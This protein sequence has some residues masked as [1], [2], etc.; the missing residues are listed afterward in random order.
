VV[1][2]LVADV[3]ALAPALT[4]AAGLEAAAAAASHAQCHEALR[5]LQAATVTAAGAAALA[6]SL[7]Q[8]RRNVWAQGIRTP[9]SARFPVVA[10]C[11][12]SRSWWVP[13]VWLTCLASR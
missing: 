8:V 12:G 6:G 5:A 1:H 4:V 7:W 9:P 3:A 10:V 11:S 13:T 2:T